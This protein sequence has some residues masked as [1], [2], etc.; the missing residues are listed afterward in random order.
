MEKEC[1]RCGNFTAYYIKAYCRY[2][3]EDC[4]RCAIKKQ[5]TDKHESCESWKPKKTDTKI[6]R[7]VIMQGLAGAITDI[8]VIKEFLE[9]NS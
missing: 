7:G 4:G 2:L 1:C 3:K 8:S 6:K 9:E 5:L